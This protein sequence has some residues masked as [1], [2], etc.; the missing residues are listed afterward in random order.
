MMRWRVQQ[1]EQIAKFISNFLVQEKLIELEETPEVLAGVIQS[2]IQKNFEE[3]EKIDEEARKLFQE[4]R[5]K[6]ALAIDE[7]LALAMIKRQIAK[8]RN[9]VL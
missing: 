2:T 5:K 4:H 8:E 3:E 7:D 1:I 9:F 6:V